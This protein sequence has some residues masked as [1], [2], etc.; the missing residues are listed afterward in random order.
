MFGTRQHA[1]PPFRIADLQ[2]DR[3]LLQEARHDAKRLIEADP[4]LSQA[5]HARLRRMV[6]AR[7]GK[8][9]DLGE[10]G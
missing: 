5:D 1:L 3:E 4:G 10:V 8:V 6:R 9:L 2:R 7:Y